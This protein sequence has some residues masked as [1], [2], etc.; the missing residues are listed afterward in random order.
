[1]AELPEDVQTT[2]ERLTRLARDAVD[3][4]EAEAYRERRESSLSE[5]GYTARYREA[6]DTL[7][8]YPVEWIDDDGTVVLDRIDDTDR[9]VELSLSGTGEEDEWAAIEE[10]NSQLV[11]TVEETAGEDHAANARAFADFMGNHYVRRVETAGTRELREF[12]TEYYPRNS[13]PTAAQKTKVRES[14]ELLFEAAGEPFPGVTRTS[15]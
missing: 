5:H 1:M 8:L 13:W 11:A 9:A 4:N 3:S 6:D 7:I 10:H 15:R 2:A 14:L 12:L